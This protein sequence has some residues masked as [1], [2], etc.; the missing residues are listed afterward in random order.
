VATATFIQS[1]LLI[2]MTIK[3][4][5]SRLQ[6]FFGISRAELT[7]ALF[8]ISCLFLASV[9]KLVFYFVSSDSRPFEQSQRLFLCLD[10]IA[11]AEKV[12]YT[13]TDINDEPM[14]ELV[15]DFNKNTKSQEKIF[16]KLDSS[17]TVRIDIN[18]ASKLE[19]MSIPGIGAKTALKIINRRKEKRFTKAD[20]LLDI[21]GIGTKKLEIIKKY[22][23]IN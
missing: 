8:V 15:T 12:Y 21:K 17:S 14:P 4:S 7:A 9:I 11:E 5:F 19:L 2:F 1:R 16:K 6:S 22:I 20:E 23:K 10:S 13:G 3:K 18:N